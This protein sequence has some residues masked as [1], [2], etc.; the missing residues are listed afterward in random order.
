M[1]VKVSRARES[2]PEWREPRTR[3][4][5]WLL[6]HCSNQSLVAS[7][8]HRG[9][10]SE[11]TATPCRQMSCSLVASEET[12]VLF[13]SAGCGVRI[14]S[15]FPRTA[16]TGKRRLVYLL[17]KLSTVFWIAVC[18][19]LMW[20]SLVDPPSPQHH[21]WE[22]AGLPKMMAASDF[23]QVGI[24]SVVMLYLL[25]H[26]CSTSDQTLSRTQAAVPVRHWYLFL[27]FC[28]TTGTK[29]KKT[30]RLGTKCSILFRFSY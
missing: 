2:P 7:E 18:R 15:P 16:H 5:D 22:I 27:G 10:S 12:V 17:P 9:W 3:M 11:T 14:P 19:A 20:R 28:A 24:S 1:S 21:Q 13:P 4:R 30:K 8:L 26:R 6:C 29:K 23:N 25:N